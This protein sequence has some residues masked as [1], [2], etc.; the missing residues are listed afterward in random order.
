MKLGENVQIHLVLVV[1]TPLSLRASAIVSTKREKKSVLSWK[2]C[3][4]GLFC[5]AAC[6]L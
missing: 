4:H 1:L 3:K 6:V 2:D 5:I